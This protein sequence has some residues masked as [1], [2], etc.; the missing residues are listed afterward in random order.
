MK[1][2]K[3]SVAIVGREDLKGVD[4]FLNPGLVN[5][6]CIDKEIISSYDIVIYVEGSISNVLKSRW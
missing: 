6:R 3:A 5:I 1:A 2:V 4:K